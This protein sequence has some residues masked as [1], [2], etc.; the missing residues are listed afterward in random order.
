MNCELYIARRLRLTPAGS[1][2]RSPAVGIAVAGVALAV[3]VMLMTTAVVVGF[4]NAIQDKVAGFEAALTISPLGRFYQNE[5]ESLHYDTTLSEVLSESLQ[6]G[7]VSLVIKQP[8]VL[9]TSDNFAGVVLYGFG[10]GHNREFESGNLI[11]GALPQK[12]TEIVISSTVAGKL[13]LKTG[14]RV[15]GCFFSGDALKLRKL[16]VS[17]LY[18]SNFSDY[19]RLVAYGEY[20]LLSKLRGYAEDEGDL[21]E[22]RGIP[23]DNIQSVAERVHSSLRKAYNRGALTS[24]VRVT[25]MFD[26]GAMYFNWLSMLDMNVVV[27]LVIMSLVSGFTLISCVFILIL[28]RVSMIGVLK[29][30][31]ATDGVIRRIFIL[32]GCRVIGLGLIFGNVIG[33]GILVAQK[34][35]KIIPLDPESYFVSYVPVDLSWGQV[36]AVN[37]GACLLGA[38][39]LLIP[40]AIVS[41]ISPAV[42][43]KYE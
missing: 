8:V 9:K 7:E 17:G 40:V 12:S 43:M 37:L 23:T 36:F 4:R 2:R 5:S 15:D 26:S 13:G 31:G 42:T 11:D 18:T 30:L 16:T 33:G 1:G 41:R 25:T 3:A 27:I 10:D 22:V 28:Q 38:L 19:D 35:Y 20:S 6:R 34:L 14:D 32:L 39:L 21:I 29:S 24:G